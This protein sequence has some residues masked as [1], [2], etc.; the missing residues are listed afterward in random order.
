MRRLGTKILKEENRREK[1]KRARLFQDLKL[2]EKN[3]GGGGRDAQ[4]TGYRSLRKK[5]GTKSE[6]P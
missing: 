3:Q 4:R 2:G 6:P 5:T 1:K